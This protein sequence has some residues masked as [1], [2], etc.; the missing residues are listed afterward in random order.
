VDRVLARHGLHL[1]GGHRP[2]RSHKAP[3]PE[4]AEWRPNQLWCWDASQ[5]ERCVASKYAYAIVDI[6]SRQWIATIL[7]PEATGT[8][9]RVLFAKAL[10]AE[11]LLSDELAQ[12]LVVLDDTSPVDDLPDV[13]LLVAISDN[14][15]EMRCRD[16]R[17]FLAVCSIAQHFGRPATPTDQAWIETLWGHLKHEHPH[18]LAITD[19]AVL[20]AEL[21]RVRVHYNSVRL[22]EAIGYVTPNDEHQ[23]RGEAIRRARRDGLDN[24]DRKRRLWH[25]NNRNQP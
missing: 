3:W 1:R 5:F 14:G 21:E 7:A 4:W 12:R 2:A 19:P 9:V 23:G 25:R 8:Q 13:P 11:G 15:T 22:H 18:L 16:T 20:A 6:V 24:A 17:R 10:D